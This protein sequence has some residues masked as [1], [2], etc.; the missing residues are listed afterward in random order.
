MTLETCT[1]VG[2]VMFRF[3]VDALGACGTRNSHEKSKQQMI[4]PVESYRRT[5]CAAGTDAGNVC[6]FQQVQSSPMGEPWAV[7]RVISK[8]EAERRLGGVEVSLEPD[9]LTFQNWCSWR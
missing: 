9:E 4:K 8:D 3:K 6:S 1:A 7:C 5:R 2:R